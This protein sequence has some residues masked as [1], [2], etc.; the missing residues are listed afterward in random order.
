MVVQTRE[1][2]GLGWAVG[3]GDG[4]KWSKKFKVLC[5]SEKQKWLKIFSTLNL[6]GS[7]T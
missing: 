3:S 6:M 4:V 5:Q 7:S 2:G 1:D